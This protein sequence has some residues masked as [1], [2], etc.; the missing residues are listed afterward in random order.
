MTVLLNLIVALGMLVVVPLGLRLVDG[1]PAGLVRVWMLGAVAG[2]TSLWLP[3]GWPAAG[4]ASAYALV[5]GLLAVAGLRRWAARPSAAPA[6]IALLTALVAPSVAGVSLVAERSGVELFGFPLPVL[7]LTVAH[8]HYAGFAAALTAA[9]SASVS[10]SY[11][12]SGDR[13]GVA[14]S[15]AAVCVPAGILVV[16]VGFFAGRVVELAGTVLLT[17]GLWLVAWL[18]WRERRTTSGRARTLFGI[19]AVVPFATMALAVHWALGR[20]VGLPHL[21]VNWM[22]ATHGLANAVG[23]A[24]CSILAWQRRTAAPV[25]PRRPP[26]LPPWRRQAVRSG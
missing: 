6:E 23:F 9:L 5:T 3:R 20:A 1:L 7:S 2:G 8:F 14:P 15:L 21:P 17:A 12:A 25:A 11:R 18:I 10:A 26:A 19:A 16:F 13:R 24:L 4:L 22:I